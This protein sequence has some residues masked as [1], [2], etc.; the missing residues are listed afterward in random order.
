MRQPLFMVTPSALPQPSVAS[1]QSFC[2]VDLCQSF[3]P[4]WPRR[5]AKWHPYIILVFDLE[6]RQSLFFSPIYDLCFLNKSW[7]L[8]IQFNKSS[9]YIS[10]QKLKQ[11]PKPNKQKKT[12]RFLTMKKANV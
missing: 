10:Q 3:Y 7:I 2:P 11:K 9:G 12:Q 5:T 6:F 4:T 1:A 8:T